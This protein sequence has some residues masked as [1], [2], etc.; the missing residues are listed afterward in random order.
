VVGLSFEDRSDIYDKFAAISN[1]LGASRVGWK[2]YFYGV[3]A[4]KYGVNPYIISNIVNQH[5]CQIN[6]KPRTDTIKKKPRTDTIKIPDQF[7]EESID[8]LILAHQ[9]PWPQ[10][11]FT[12]YREEMLMYL[13]Y[14][15]GMQNAKIARL[16][17]GDL[18]HDSIIYS[19]WLSVRR[20]SKEEDPMIANPDGTRMHLNSLVFIINKIE[21]RAGVTPHSLRKT[22]MTETQL[23]RFTNGLTKKR[24][25]D[26]PGAPGNMLNSLTDP[27]RIF[28]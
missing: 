24:W 28:A 23:V 4:I 20:G 18:P 21:S 15:L 3:F 22:R 13:V 27:K 2:D 14:G 11:V 25:Y 10:K 1:D 8:L 9:G 16:N 12:Y 5:S 26:I 6:S 17:L 19:R 7:P